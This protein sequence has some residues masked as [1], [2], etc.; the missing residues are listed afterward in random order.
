MPALLVKPRKIEMA[1][2]RL[3]AARQMDWDK[4]AWRQPASLRF[5]IRT[6]EQLAANEEENPE[7]RIEAERLIKKLYA[8]GKE[9]R[10]K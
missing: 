10:F 9:P 3:V 6:L 5:I 4:E 8:A 7:S 2:L 1:D